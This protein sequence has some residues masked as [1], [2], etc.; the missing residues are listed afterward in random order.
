MREKLNELESSEQDVTIAQIE[1]PRTDTLHQA[2]HDLLG[3][4]C[5]DSELPRFSAQELKESR[6]F[7]RS[8]SL[9]IKIKPSK[10]RDVLQVDMAAYVLLKV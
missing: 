9:T 7:D 5:F 2:L 1:I 8:E 3:H 10:L 4:E 6:Y